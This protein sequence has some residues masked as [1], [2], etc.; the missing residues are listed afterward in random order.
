MLAKVYLYRNAPGD[1]A[2]ALAETEEVM[3]DNQYKLVP[4]ANYAD[5]F[6]VGK[7]NTSETIF[8]ISYR[9]NSAVESQ[10]LDRETVPYPNNNPRILPEQKII[11]AFRANPT[12]LR[13]PISLGVHNN[14]TYTRKYEPAPPTTNVRGVQTSN[15]IILRLADVILMRAEALN[16]L[17]RTGDAVPFLNQI[18]ER[19]GLTP[20][21]ATMQE[22]VRLAIENERYLELAFEGQRWFDL[23]RT[24]RATQLVPQ[25]TN[26]ERILWPVPAREIDLNPNLLPQNPSY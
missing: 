24:G 15:V 17:G 13:L 19:A 7:Q 10:S 18:R 26:P 21:T 8:E 22:E 25:L 20:T 11:N 4:G 9:P 23:V 5:L 16:E 3:A 1:Y 14:I 12:D 2:L 6:T